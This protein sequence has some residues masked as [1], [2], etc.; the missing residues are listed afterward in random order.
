MYGCAAAGTSAS[1][2]LVALLACVWRHAL[3]SVCQLGGPARAVGR[4]TVA[5][6]LRYFHPPYILLQVADASSTGAQRLGPSAS[7]ASIR[8]ARAGLGRPSHAKAMGLDYYTVLGLNRRARPLLCCLRLASPPPSSPLLATA[9]S[10][11]VRL[12]P[13]PGCAGRRSTQTLRKRT[14]ALRHGCS[15]CRVAPHAEPQL[16]L[17][18]PLELSQRTAPACSYRKLALRYHPSNADGPDAAREF[19]RVSEAYDVLSSCALLPLKACAVSTTAPAAPRHTKS[20]TL[21]STTAAHA[22]ARSQ[23]ERRV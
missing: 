14:R 23:V 11:E 10:T 8:S 6:R 9:N 12:I 18:R 22:L 2:R 5:L 19:A 3:P 13:P 17:S 15:Q 20:D 1:G 4:A 16:N 21:A 7:P